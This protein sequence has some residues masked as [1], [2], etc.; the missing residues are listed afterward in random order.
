MA[1]RSVYI[2]DENTGA[3][4][5]VLYRDNGDGTYSLTTTTSG[6]VESTSDITGPL[7]R[8]AD[9]ASVSV[10]LSTEDVAFLDSLES[11]LDGVETS[12][13]T[14]ATQTTLAAVLAKLIAAPATE[15]KQD[16]QIT[17]LASI[18]AKIAALGTAGTPSSDVIS[19]QGISGGYPMPFISVGS[20]LVP[21]VTVS[22]TPAY[23]VGDNIGGLITLTNAVRAS[24]TRAF[25]RSVFL[26]DTSN[27]K[28]AI[29]LLFFNASP[30][31][32][33]FTDN[34]AAVL[35]SSDYAKLIRRV[36]IAA[37]DYTTIDS[38]GIADIIASDRS[39]TPASGTSLYLALVIPSNGGT[40]TYATTSALTLRLNMLWD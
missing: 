11:Y 38:K 25:L 21:T 18:L 39:L 32:S 20:T 37:T 14:L 40:P 34:A 29:D 33:T 27:Q 7:G 6:D 4:V 22:T 10:A 5:P 2:R 16:T 17:S 9:A 8:K 12:L 28:N 1:D 31:S 15:A 13:G 24:G 19:T 35:H 36:S 30:S 26:L 23:S 3:L